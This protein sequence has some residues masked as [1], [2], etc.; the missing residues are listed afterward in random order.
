MQPVMLSV[1]TPGV[2]CALIINGAF[3]GYSDRPALV[4]AAETGELMLTCLPLENAGACIALP[5]TVRLMFENGLP[6]ACPPDGRLYF[7]EN[8][9]VTL[10]LALP[11]LPLHQ[12]NGLP[13]AV[14]RVLAVHRGATCTATLFLGAPPMLA[15]ESADGAL[16][17]LHPLPDLVT[18][19]LERAAFFT[20]QDILLH[21]QTAQGP[22]TILFSPISGQW[23][24]AAEAHGRAETAGH[25]LLVTEQLDDV[26]GH[27]R[28]VRFF[29]QNNEVQRAPAQIGFFTRSPRA[30]QT[31]EAAVRALCEAVALGAAA[32]ALT[33]MTPALRQGLDEQELLSFFGPIDHVCSVSGEP[34]IARLAQ[35]VAENV[36]RVYSFRFETEG[37]AI[38]NIEPLA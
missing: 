8:G 21:G 33:L 10:S 1:Q 20:P 7:G 9:L 17:C 35:A 31:P 15:I 18:G 36:F 5:R 4:P 16:L 26:R 14:A 25:E 24:A 3:C 38:Q 11:V 28:R 12:N 32:E 22:Q 13:R 29:V 23:Q 37:T 30:P 6:L 2:P 19:T 27:Q 34:P